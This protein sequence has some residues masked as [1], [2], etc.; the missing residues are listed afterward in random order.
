MI[1]K[2]TVKYLH[3]GEKILREYKTVVISFFLLSLFV[4]IAFLTDNS[5]IRFFILIPIYII[6]SR[7][8][9]FTSKRT[10]LLCFILTIIM[11]LLYLFIGP[12]GPTEKTA[13]WIYLFLAVG[14]IQQFR[15]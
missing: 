13:V 8:Y 6:A 15:E 4:D 9:R 12:V 11:G 1:H 10:F 3:S 14:I 5:D 7:T 2:I